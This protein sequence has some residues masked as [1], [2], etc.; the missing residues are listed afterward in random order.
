VYY[1]SLGPCERNGTLALLKLFLFRTKILTHNLRYK[2][3]EIVFTFMSPSNIFFKQKHKRA[4]QKTFKDRGKKVFKF[5]S[6]ATINNKIEESHQLGFIGIW[7]QVDI[8]S[9]FGHGQSQMP[10]C[11]MFIQIACLLEM[12][13]SS[14]AYSFVRWWKAVPNLRFKL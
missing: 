11:H 3:F 2:I 10:R 12:V 14:H 5:P 13:F 4:F 6:H 1:Y 8:T 7:Y 9:Y